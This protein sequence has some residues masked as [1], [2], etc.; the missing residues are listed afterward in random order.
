MYFPVG[1]LAPP[2]P[3]RLKLTINISQSAQKYE[4]S[5]AYLLSTF[6]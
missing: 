3:S 2:G 1:A 6:K 5:L 4:K